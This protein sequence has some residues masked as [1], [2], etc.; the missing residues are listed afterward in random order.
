[1]S[2]MWGIESVSVVSA[3]IMLS[4]MMGSESVS[5]VSAKITMSAMRRERLSL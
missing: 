5:V 2:A 3:K 1:M 4:A